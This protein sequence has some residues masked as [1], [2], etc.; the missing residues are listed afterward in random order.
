MEYADTTQTDYPDA[1]LFYQPCIAISFYNKAA[2]CNED[3]VW[4]EVEEAC[5][6]N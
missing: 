4:V 3:I 5:G 1:A 2:C 6:E